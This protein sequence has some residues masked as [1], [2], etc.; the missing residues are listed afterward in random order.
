MQVT[1]FFSYYLETPGNSRFSR[2]HVD[3][4]KITNEKKKQKKHPTYTSIESQLLKSIIFQT[5]P[6]LE[7]KLDFK[8]NQLEVCSL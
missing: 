2:S 4:L 8:K 5:T 6:D 1:D 3:I 7:P